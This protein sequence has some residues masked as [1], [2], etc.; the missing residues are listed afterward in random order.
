[1]GFV[2][3]LV[4]AGFLLLGASLWFDAAQTMR[5][6]QSA[7]AR[8]AQR[9]DYAEAALKEIH[10]ETQALRRTQEKKA[11]LR[12]AEARLGEATALLLSRKEVVLA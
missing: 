11:G 2:E 10:R 12:Q 9:L 1:M 3:Q 4:L 5:E 8:S 7:I 6:A